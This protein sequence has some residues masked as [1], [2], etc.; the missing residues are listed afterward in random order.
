MDSA[1]A[2][3]WLSAGTILMVIIASGPLV[4]AV[5]LTQ[6][7]DTPTD[8]YGVFIGNGVSA[9]RQLFVHV[10]ALNTSELELA[11]TDGGYEVTVPEAAVIVDPVGKQANLTYHLSIPEL[12]HTSAVNQTVPPGDQQLVTFAER[13][14]TGDA[15]LDAGTYNATVWVEITHRG[16]TFTARE[17]TVTV[18]T[19]AAA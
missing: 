3:R 19:E 2:F 12:N 11:D 16:Q 13:I 5:S 7:S 10:T 6:P 18:H 4:P 17:E 8:L 1:R 15:T 9:E 14:E